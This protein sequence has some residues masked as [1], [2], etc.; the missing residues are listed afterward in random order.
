MIFWFG[1]A[2]LHHKIINKTGSTKKENSA[3]RFGENC[4]TNHLVN[5]L[6][7]RM[8]PW[9]VGAL[10]GRIHCEIIFLSGDF[11]KC[12]FMVISW[13]MKYFH[14]IL[15]RQYPKFIRVMFLIN[16]KIVNDIVKRS[17][18]RYRVNFNWKSIM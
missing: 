3:H 2:L 11:M 10:K 9:R 7:D 13:S 18:R 6:Q 5:F 1:K 15:L 16:K 14:E 17:Q 12:S 4:L 8:K